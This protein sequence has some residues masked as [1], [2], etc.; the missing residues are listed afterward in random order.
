V[1]EAVLKKAK[2]FS[3]PDEEGQIIGLISQVREEE[4]KILEKDIENLRPQL[5]YLT[6]LHSDEVRNPYAV[7]IPAEGIS[8]G[9]LILMSGTLLKDEPETHFGPRRFKT[10]TAIEAVTQFGLDKIS[11]S[12]VNIFLRKLKD[13]EERKT[14]LVERLEKL[15]KVRDV[16]SES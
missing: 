13:I 4:A 10:M 2:E 16:L 3:F 14:R 11:E 9:L 12:L 6:D 7:V 5:K 1:A 15:Q 8:D